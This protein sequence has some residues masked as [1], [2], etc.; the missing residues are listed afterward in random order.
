M[1]SSVILFNKKLLDDMGF[2]A[3]KFTKFRVLNANMLPGFRMPLHERLALPSLT[4]YSS[5]CPHN[6]ALGI[7]FP[8]DAGSGPNNQSPRRPQDCKNDGKGVSAGYRTHRLFLQLESDL[9]QQG[10]S[11]PHRRLYPNAQGKRFRSRQEPLA[12]II[13]ATTPV[14]VLFTTWVF[15][16]APPSLKTLG[17]VSLIVIGVVIACYGEIAFVLTGVLYQAGGIIFEA[18]RL[19]LVQRLLNSAEFKMDP[20]VS[21]YYFAP[22]CTVMNGV[23]SLFTEIPTMTMDDIYRVGIYT[24]VANAMVAFLLNVS[25]VF[26][27]SVHK[28]PPLRA[29]LK[30]LADW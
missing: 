30:F 22:V 14:A 8:H 18:I 12:D 13:E 17:N 3:S 15:G 16:M 20:L 9:R 28:S 6:M 2:S 4:S 11:I 27:V 23:T 26:L 24:L 19:T 7:C 10:L 25:V 1:S 5:Y 29:G 21:L